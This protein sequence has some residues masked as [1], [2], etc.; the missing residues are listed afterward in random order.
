MPQT[1]FVQTR[2]PRPDLT[3]QRRQPRRHP[4]YRRAP[5]SGKGPQVP[6]CRRELLRAPLA[7]RTSR[8]GYIMISATRYGCSAARNRGTCANRKTIARKDVETRVLNGLETRLMHPDLIREYIT[9]WQQEMQ[10]ERR[11]TLAARG[12]QERRLAKVLRDIEN[13]V[14]AITEGMF[15]P[16]MKAKMDALE[17]ER[18]DLEAKL[19][20]LPE[21]EPVAIHP[22]LAE[23]YAR[24]VADL[25]AAL[26]D[27]EARPEA[28]G[29]LRGLIESVT[30]TP[31]ADAPN[32]HLIE[33]RGELGAI[34]SL[35][36]NDVATNANARRG[37]AGV[38]QVTMV[39]GARIGLCRTKGRL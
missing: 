10:A 16:S 33:L 31:D 26:N 21:P 12:E 13:I 19:A 22:S 34:L 28:A 8:S 11:E 30:L 6:G 15:H 32:G 17:G 38:R 18:A 9:T 20:A 5:I 23:T 27:P 35:C 25:A 29:L 1:S 24:K 2:L 7:P 4:A 37:A 39:A 14:T 3:G 36:G